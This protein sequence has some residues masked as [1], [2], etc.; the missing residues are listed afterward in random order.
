VTN[1]GKKFFSVQNILSWVMLD[2][3]GAIR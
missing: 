1:T 3:G 2:H